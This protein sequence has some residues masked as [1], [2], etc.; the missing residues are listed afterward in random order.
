MTR[1]FQA[2]RI[3]LCLVSLLTV[4]QSAFADI[5]F[6]P[7]SGPTTGGFIMRV[8]GSIG[9]LVAN[10]SV[11]VGGALCVKVDSGFFNF[12]QQYQRCR[13]PA[14]VGS[15]LVVSTGSDSATA[16][17]SYADPVISSRSPTASHFSGGVTLSIFGSNF[18][19]SAATTT[20]RMGFGGPICPI[21]SI[22]STHSAIT[23]TLPP[24]AAGT[25]SIIV[26]AG[27][28]SSSPISFQYTS[29][30]P[31]FSVAG[32]NCAPCGLGRYSTNGNTP[33][34]TLASVGFFVPVTTASAQTACAPG[35]YSPT[36]GRS[37]CLP[38]PAGHFV[39]ESAAASATPCAVGFFVSST[40]AVACNPAPAGSFVAT[41]GATA[42]ALCAPNTFQPLA[43]QAACLPCDA[44]RISTAGATACVCAPPPEGSFISNPDTCEVSAIAPSLR[45]SAVCVK[46]DPEDATRALVQFGYENTLP[47]GGAIADVGSVSINGINQVP[48][49]IPPSLASGIHTNAF[50]V[51]YPMGGSVVWTAIDPATLDVRTASPTGSTPSCTS[52]GPAGPAG[53]PGETGPEGPA[54]A[55]GETGPAGP[56][57]PTG[58]PGPQGPEGAQGPPGTP[59]APGA[60]A[61]LPAGTI[62]M[63]LE[64]DPAP[65]GFTFIGSFTQ[66]FLKEPD[67]I[68]KFIV[69]RMY[70]K[71]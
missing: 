68:E 61:T 64:T 43:A 39:S 71:D 42:P 21:T 7:S 38:S 53:L 18:G 5:T 36:T 4:P 66:K 11:T 10:A 28:Q 35:S 25:T 6:S 32:G 45:L 47:S 20:V 41:P 37:S 69:I 65:A 29:C 31:G 58:P 49:G 52:Q 40:G 2:L 19:P 34:C 17:F 9:T 14:G 54:G 57:G 46:P 24:G 30:S 55:Q 48:A 59:G 50:T 62:V 13:V 15:N 70:R 51:R 22:N 12:I 33:A 16:R 1:L 3:P 67:P 56:E 63:L 23:C 44:G 26:F 27:N 60:P 8:E